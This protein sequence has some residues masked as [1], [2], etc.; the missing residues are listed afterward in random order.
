M[1]TYINKY[2]NNS[3]IYI[4]IYIYMYIY[5]GA[6]RALPPGSGTSTGWK[7][8]GCTKWYLVLSLWFSYLF[9]Y[10]LIPLSIFL[11]SLV[12]LQSLVLVVFVYTRSGTLNAQYYSYI[13]LL[14]Q[15]LLLLLLLMIINT[16]G[17]K[18]EGCTKWYL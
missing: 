13:S 1:N 4:Y 17:W 15:L 7:V 8:E 10:S 9:N 6:L 12:L 16:I 14:L 3:Y 11:W 2:T 18:V 5:R